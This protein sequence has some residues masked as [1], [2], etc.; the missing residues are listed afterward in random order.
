MSCSGWGRACSGG[1]TLSGNSGSSGRGHVPGDVL[2]E[3]PECEGTGH[4]EPFEDLRVQAHVR[5][6]IRTSWTLGGLPEFVDLKLCKWAHMLG[7][8][9]H[10]STKSRAYSTALR[11]VRRAW[12]LAQADAARAGHPAPGPDSMLVTDSSWAYLA[13]GYRPGEELLAA[14]TR[15]EINETRADNERAK[16]EGEVWQ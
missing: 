4:A 2:A 1:L 9:G 7:F 10:F 5:Q 11:D 15:H 3:C 16:T 14:Q 6:M 12:R 13:S 8:R